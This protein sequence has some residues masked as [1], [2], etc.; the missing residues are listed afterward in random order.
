MNKRVYDKIDRKNIINL[1]KNSN[2]LL[3]SASGHDIIAF[4]EALIKMFINGDCYTVSFILTDNFKFDILLGSDFVYKYKGVL[5]FANNTMILNKKVI[6][7]RPK[8]ELPKCGLLQV[9]TLQYVEPYTV[10]HIEVRSKTQVK[11]TC[12][13]LPLD[14][15]KLY[16]N[17]PGVNSPSTAVNSN[18]KQKYYIPVI[19]NTGVRRSIHAR[20]ILGFIEQVNIQDSKVRDDNDVINNRQV[21]NISKH[22]VNTDATPQDKSFHIGDHTTDIQKSQ[23]MNVI[24]NYKDIFVDNNKELKVTNI[25]QATLNTGDAAPIRQRPYRNPLLLQGEIDRQVDEMLEA[26]IISPSSSPWSSPVVMVPKRD[27]SKRLCI[28]YRRLNLTL[29]KD[30]FPMP[31]IDDLF[32]TLGK[33]KFFSCLDLKSGYHQIEIAPEDRE[34]TAFCTRNQLLEYNVLPFGIS[35]GTSIFQRMISRVLK[36][37]SGKFALAYLDD[38]LIF[39]ETFGDHIKHIEEVFIRLQ[40]ASLSLNRKKCHF[41]K[42][43][44]EYLGHLIS[45][46]GIRPN[47]EKVRAIQTLDPPTSVKQV[48][49]FLGLASYYRSFVPQFSVIARPLTQ[50]TRKNITFSWND[51]AQQ[52]FEYLKTKLTEAPVLAYPDVSRPYSLYTDASDFA[53]GGILTQ[54]FEE[55]ERVIQ[56]VSHQLTP[57]RLNY[58]CIERECYAIIYCITKL[59]QYLLGADVTVYTD[60]KP[61]KSLFTA[62]MKNTRVQ[63]WAILL[64]EYQ[65]K[66]KYRSGQHNLC[67]DAM[68]RMR[69]KPTQDELEEAQEILEI[70]QLPQADI[71]SKFPNYEAIPFDKDL[72]MCELQKNDSF[73]KQ[74]FKQLEN[75][76][77]KVKHDYVMKD[78]LLYHIGKLFR[79]E[80]EPILQLVVP[81][82][83]QNIVL[84][85]Y[86]SKFGGGHV[87][88]VK[89]YQKIRSKYFWP[90]S[91]K[92]VVDYV[93]KCDVCQ[94]RMLRKKHAE[95]QDSEMPT[96]PMQCVGIDT[97]GPF[98]TSQNGNN[99][100]I[101][102]VDWYSNWIE[103]YP[104]PNKE[105]DTIASVILEQFIPRHGCMDYLVS[106]N[107]SE[108]RNQAID[109]VSNYMRINRNLSSPYHPEGNGRTE[110]SHRFLNDIISKGVQGRLHSEWEQMLPAALF[111]MRTSVND[112]TRYTPFF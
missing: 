7:L 52:S 65:I 44:I 15:N 102:M 90:N 64:D 89:T 10:S 94:R 6:R 41:V 106:D 103:A 62:E 75:N 5:D 81:E 28:D 1:K 12:I 56:Y 109:L 98:V 34:K 38:I 25:L 72:D 9:T 35:S 76:D 73:C 59:K 49:S 13:V 95:L 85:G 47:P 74:I 77:D 84:E 36:G 111:A 70:E 79:Y 91:Y 19:N 24:N 30:S 57:N 80:T 45:G 112:S 21:N 50:L 69:I 16:E 31:R 11:G 66:I 101:T 108:F 29:I 2:V 71:K 63:R 83:L 100:I 4:G 3:K 17:Q 37:I 48:R 58:P 20:S 55:G 88:L 67:A 42:Q 27:G 22:I 68:S 92:H 105:A 110:R 8:H 82:T 99:Y 39:S 46:I 107:G 60:H 93:I 53:V 14:H 86:H 51:D 78:K 18:S 23:L 96:G 32:A 26:G 54:D 43:E 33:A 97:V 40:Q 87:G 104:V 61:L